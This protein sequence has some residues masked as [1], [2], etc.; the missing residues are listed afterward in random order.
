V[1]VRLLAETTDGPVWVLACATIVLA[2]ATAVLA[3]AAIRALIQLDEVKRDRHVEV[4][5]QMGLRW[6]S[7]EMTDALQLEYHH[8]PDSLLALFEMAALDFRPRNALQRRRQL[9]AQ[10]EKVVLLRVPNY[11]EEAATIAEVGG[12]NSA[13]IDDYFGGIA[14]DE[15][16]LW[17]PTIKRL[18]ENDPEAFV[19]FE[20]LA[21]QSD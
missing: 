7:T 2:I 11:F 13:L 17:R 10:R 15:W 3:G 6:S 9:R 16:E 21:A 4:F 18:Q 8:D 5:S 1:T 20:R 12:L 19:Q 14:K